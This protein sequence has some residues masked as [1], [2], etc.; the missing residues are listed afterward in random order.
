MGFLLNRGGGLPLDL[1]RKIWSQR[2]GRK[3]KGGKL[4]MK[5]VLVNF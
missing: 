4:N 2:R 3:R 5:P 1:K